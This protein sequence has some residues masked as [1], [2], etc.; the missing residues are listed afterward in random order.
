MQSDKGKAIANKKAYVVLLKLK[1]LK[2][3]HNVMLN[4][5]QNP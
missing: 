5:F 2:T 4:L 1:M 3:I